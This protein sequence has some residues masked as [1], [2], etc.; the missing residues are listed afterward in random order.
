[1]NNYQKTL[2]S[3]N[4]TI[5]QSLA[6]ID[7]GAMKIGI[8]VDENKKLLGTLTDGDIRRAI[9][10]GG[11]LDDSIKTIYFRTP[12]TCG[13]N[14]SKEKILQLAVAHKLFQIPI[15][16]AEGR[17]IGIAEVDE[18]LQSARHANKV[19]LMAGGLGTRLS[20]LTD[21]TPKPM[22]HVGNK[23]ILET[24]IENFSKYGYTDII[25]S[26]SYKSHIIEEYFGDGAAFG[27]T[28][29]YVHEN[30]RMGTAG[31]LSLVRD[32]LSEP[33]FVMNG[34]V[35]TN[36]NFEHLYDYHLSHDAVATMAVREYDFQVPYG[37]VNVQDNKI[38][39]IEEKPTHKF[40]VNAGIYML[41][42]QVLELIPS[43]NF[44]DMPTLF[45][46]LISDKHNAV[47]FPIREYWLDIGRMSDYERANNEYS[48]I[49]S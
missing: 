13:I 36:I 30:K 22:L 44:F 49:F 18:L 48:S 33:F 21:T 15:V 9:L 27:V 16:D 45:E 19:V 28:I 41:S 46:K 40:F 17:I 20:P 3:P 29:D 37:V 35:L 2:L 6:I 39:S 4:A 14:D 47:S 5:R 7:N 1:M 10:N 11:G 32:K 24:I 42:P 34:D 23:P 25:L 12:T 43:D 26:V 8:V 31:A 38:V